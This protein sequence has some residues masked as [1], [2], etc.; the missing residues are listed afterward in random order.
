LDRV[1]FSS[2][3]EPARA[4]ESTVVR[5][6]C[7]QVEHCTG[8]VSHNKNC[9]NTSM[10][11]QLGQKFKPPT[12]SHCKLTASASSRPSSL[13]IRR[14]QWTTSRTWSTCQ[15]ECQCFAA[16]DSL[17]PI[18]H[19]SRRKKS[20]YSCKIQGLCGYAIVPGTCQHE[21]MLKARRTCRLEPLAVPQHTR[22]DLTCALYLDLC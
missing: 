12:R 16:I 14:C 20:S 21:L 13:V 9:T 11:L 5:F 22:R 1:L 2:S 19:N 3:L 6:M 7:L 18:E 17:Y 10:A 4:C 15:P 8:M